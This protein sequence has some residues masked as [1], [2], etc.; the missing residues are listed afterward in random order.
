MIDV[1]SRMPLGR[2]KSRKSNGTK[3]RDSQSMLSCESRLRRLKG[4]DC[5]ASI[6]LTNIEVATLPMELPLSKPVKFM[7]Y[8]GSNENYTIFRIFDLLLQILNHKSGSHLIA[9]YF[10]PF[11]S[12]FIIHTQKAIIQALERPWFKNTRLL[13]K[14]QPLFGRAVEKYA[15]I[16]AISF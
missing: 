1:K 2:S 10:L 6:D 14:L 4:I 15:A 5:C 12:R 11:Y 9:Y 3:I 16:P 8:G 7:Q 13:R